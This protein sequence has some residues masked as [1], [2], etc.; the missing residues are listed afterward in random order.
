[1]GERSRPLTPN[2]VSTRPASSHALRCLSRSHA[3]VAHASNTYVYLGFQLQDGLN[4][5]RHV[6][7]AV[8]MASRVGDQALRVL[9]A[10]HTSARVTSVTLNAMA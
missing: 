3:P 6:E 8:L 1:M 5:H 9:P 4:S 7:E 10:T 2:R